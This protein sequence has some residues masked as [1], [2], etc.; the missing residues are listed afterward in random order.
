[1]V[2]STR[3]ARLLEICR[4]SDFQ[5]G[6]FARLFFLDSLLEAGFV[7]LT[8]DT[9]F[10]LVGQDDIVVVG[11]YVGSRDAQVFLELEKPLLNLF[12]VVVHGALTALKRNPAALQDI[13]PL[14]EGLVSSAS[15]ILH[16]INQHRALHRAQVFNDF[17]RKQSI[18]Q[19]FVL[20]NV[21]FVVF[22]EPPIV[23]VCFFDVDEEEISEMC[24]VGCELVE[25]SQLH[26]ERG[27]GG[28][29]EVDD[30][31]AARPREVAQLASRDPVRLDKATVD[32][33]AAL[34]R[35]SLREHRRFVLHDDKRLEELPV[36]RGESPVVK[37]HTCRHTAS[38]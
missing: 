28:A 19:C 21:I 24:T 17:R 15:L 13:Q 8:F 6:V 25:A 35:R 22:E 3:S 36:A 27:S 12:N 1:M 7:A 30:E 14:R 32:G 33:I 16:R 9:S 31:G 26:H 4:S 38:V 11:V 34:R 23:W 37:S 20:G 18:R 2:S 5:V 29:A 10:L